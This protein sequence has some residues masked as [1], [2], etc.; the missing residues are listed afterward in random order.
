MLHLLS[1]PSSTIPL[2]VTAV[3]DFLGILVYDC[4]DKKSL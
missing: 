3:K 1:W 2:K 4:I